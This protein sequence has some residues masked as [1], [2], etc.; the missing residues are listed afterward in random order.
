MNCCDVK[1]CHNRASY[2]AHMSPF[3]EPKRI[4]EEHWIAMMRD[5]KQ[6]DFREGV[7]GGKDCTSIRSD[8]R[9]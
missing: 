9:S 1:E 6:L 2:N 7:D 3:K 5:A 8:F 4:C